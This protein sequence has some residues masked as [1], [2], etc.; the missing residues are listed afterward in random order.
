MACQSGA[1]WEEF[2]GIRI[3]QKAGESEESLWTNERLYW[4]NGGI[5]KQ[6]ARGYFTSVFKCYYVTVRGG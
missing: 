5:Y 1:I 6:K 3:N 4:A 2:P